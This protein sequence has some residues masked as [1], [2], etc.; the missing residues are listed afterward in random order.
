MLAFLHSARAD[1]A[2]IHPALPYVVLA[3]L[4]WLFVY[5]WRKFAP[6]SFA[7][8]P[9]AAQGLPAILFSAVMGAVSGGGD[10]GKVFTD[11]LLGALSG[12]AAI[13]GHEFAKA[14]PLPYTGALGKVKPKPPEDPPSADISD[15]KPEADPEEKTPVL[16]LGAALLLASVLFVACGAL[17][18]A[19]TANDIARQLCALH[20][21]ERQGISLEDAGKT[22]CQDIRPWLDLVLRAKRE[23]VAVSTHPPELYCE[24]P[25]DAGESI[26]DAGSD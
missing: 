25:D 24:P 18:P 6:T 7:K 10:V 5:G 26:D 19:R 11:A 17:G 22:F 23:G 8:L 9:E 12:F 21:A 1:L 2:Q 16:K 4:S 14:S 3:G 13:G 15:A 20:Y